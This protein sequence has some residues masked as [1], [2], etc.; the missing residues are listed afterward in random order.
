MLDFSV[1]IPTFNR[2][3]SLKR[4]LESLG[5]LEYPKDQFEAL[6]VNDGG[7]KLPE[8][9]ITDVSS[10]LNL[11][12]LHQDNSGPASARNAGVRI[13]RGRFIALTDDDCSPKSNWLSVLKERFDHNSHCAIA[14]RTENGLRRNIY[15]TASQ[16]LIDYLSDYYNGRHGPH[17]FGTSNNLAFPREAL[18]D[19]GGFDES[20]PSSAGEDRELVD[21]WIGLN[22]EVIYAPEV[23]VVHFHQMNLRTYSR[24]HI[25]YGRGAY[26][27]HKIRS[28]RT[29]DIL[30]P[31]PLSFYLGMMGYSYQQR[32]GLYRS[33]FIS[34][35]IAWSQFMNASGFFVEKFL[36]VL[37]RDIKA[38]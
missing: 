8:N 7:N 30:K 34:L 33:T 32:Y 3:E 14:G 23:V 17:R 24:Q 2:P 1:V 35:L 28:L 22:N 19:A 27:Y 25:N 6:I 29:S 38:T 9:L 15:S 21:R 4:C 10:K 11:K 20:F 18:V 16:T 5:Q 31:E 12:L 26:R 36:S 37:T 13:A